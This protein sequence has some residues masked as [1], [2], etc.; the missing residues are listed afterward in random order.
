VTVESLASSSP[1]RVLSMPTKYIAFFAVTVESARRQALPLCFT[2]GGKKIGNRGVFCLAVVNISHVYLYFV[3]PNIDTY[4]P[5]FLC[6][7][8]IADIFTLPQKK[9]DARSK[10]QSSSTNRTQQWGLRHP[11]QRVTSP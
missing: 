8:T 5:C 7:T 3:V 2:T 1:I 6:L 11:F 9:L 10:N 4:R